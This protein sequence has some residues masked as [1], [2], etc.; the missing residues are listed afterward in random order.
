MQ[1]FYTLSDCDGTPPVRNHDFISTESHGGPGC[2]RV[3]RGDPDHARRV[4]QA[5]SPLAVALLVDGQP[6]GLE[7]LHHG[8]P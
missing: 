1:G 4:R 3:F 5:V 8:P 6:D 2:G 7:A